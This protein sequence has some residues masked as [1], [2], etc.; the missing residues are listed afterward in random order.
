[1]S[2][3]D[4]DEPEVVTEF[5]D[6]L[7]LR[8]RSRVGQTLRGKWRLDALIGVGGMAAVYAATHRNGSRAAVKILHAELST[9]PEVRGRFTREG[10]LANAVG[11]E[12]AVKVLDDDEADD[13]SLY[14]VTELLDGETL[15]ERRLRFDGHLQEDDVLSVADQLLDVLA[16]AHGKGIVHRDLKPENIFLTRAGQVKVLDFG[17]ARLR[18]LST[19]SSTATKTGSA[20]GTPAFMAPEQARGLWG[21]VDGRSDLWAVGATLFTLLSGHLVHDGRTP[22]EVLLSA[23]TKPAP[24]L[25]SVAP[26]VGPA[27]AH[28]VDRALAFDKAKRWPSAA[29]MQDAVRHAYHDRN[30]RPI[31]TSPRL[32]VPETVPD[33]TVGATANAVAA[34]QPTTARPVAS[35]QIGARL[36]ALSA[37]PGR[38]VVA[39]A[40]GAVVIVGILWAAAGTHRDE[41]AAASSIP[42]ATTHAPSAP[43]PMTA[44]PEPVKI[45]PP[46]IAATDL[47]TA[48]ARPAPTEPTPAAPAPS[49][50]IAPRAVLAANPSAAPKTTAAPSPPAPAQPPPAQV[51]AK[52]NCNPP[53][54]ID[55][56]TGK[57]H[58]KVECL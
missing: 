45:P 10:H 55:P 15:E 28:L 24:P 41:S 39:V 17:I 22:N 33:R 56:A 34:K 43:A 57:K 29:R 52:P 14:L 7:V 58:F 9:S 12:G 48:T 30:G 25:A 2:N 44:S 42:S 6:P 8:A 21:E 46:S 40:A 11:H 23:M 16:A 27:V 1:M 31:T 49:A 26:G 47:P 38:V 18:E 54:V 37:A 35:S 50:V 36:A 51:P 4:A 53:F 19:G 20:M 5:L 3:V 13:G 32:T